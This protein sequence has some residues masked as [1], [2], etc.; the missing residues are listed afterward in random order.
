MANRARRRLSARPSVCEL[1]IARMSQTR[2]SHVDTCRYQPILDVCCELLA[3]KLVKE[4]E[5]V[6]RHPDFQRVSVVSQDR[7]TTSV[8]ASSATS[9]HERNIAQRT[10]QSF[11][12]V[13]YENDAVLFANELTP[14]N[15]RAVSRA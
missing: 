6:H 2:K 12:P 7:G 3:A 8:S 15:A 4:R 1:M 14:A 11:I 9:C 13:P 5:A 10:G